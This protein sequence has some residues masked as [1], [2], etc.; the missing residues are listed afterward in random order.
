[1]RDGS[2]VGPPIADACPVT[3]NLET[4]EL[5]EELLELT[6]VNRKGLAERLGRSKGFVTQILSGDRNMTCGPWPILPLH[7]SIASRSRHCP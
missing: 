7:L 4:T 3:L 2:E 6:G 5:I 1:L